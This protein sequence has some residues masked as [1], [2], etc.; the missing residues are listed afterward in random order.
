MAIIGIVIKEKPFVTNNV[1]S[2]HNIDY[3]Y[4]INLQQQ[5]IDHS[6]IG[7]DTSI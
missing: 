7:Q 1:Y 5:H 3:I 2:L 6:L 4:E